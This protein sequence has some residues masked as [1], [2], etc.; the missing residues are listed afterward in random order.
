MKRINQ[1]GKEVVTTKKG[2]A[3]S[4]LHNHMRDLRTLF[5]AARDRYNNED[6]GIHR[7]KHYPFKNYKIGSAPLTPKRNNTLQQVVLIKNLP[8]KIGSRLELARDIYLLSF[9]QCGMNAVDLYKLMPGHIQNGRIDYNRSKTKG[10]RKD[11]AFI[12]I[13]IADDAK[14]LLEKYLGQLSSRYSKASSLNTALSKG[15]RQL[16]SKLG[17]PNLTLYWARHTFATVARNTCRMHK[18]DVAEA[19]N[20]VDERNRMTDIYIA[21]DWTIVDDVQTAVLNAFKKVEMKLGKKSD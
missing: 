17:I 5:N 3:D 20:H 1:L 4:G 6:L 7:I 15:M 11:N 10:K 16:R 14:P 19:M 9:Y 13:K 2:L 21:K 12:S 8:A 18:D